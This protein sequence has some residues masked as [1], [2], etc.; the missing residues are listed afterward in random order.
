[1]TAE[2]EVREHVVTRDEAGTRLDRLVADL[3]FVASRAFA[4]RLA[5]RGEIR[6]DGRPASKKHP[7]RAGERVVVN[8]PPPV[9][10]RLVAQDLP[11]DIRYED[12][13]L[14]VLSKPAGLVVHPAAGHADGT[15]V[16][17]LLGYCGDSLGSAGGVNRPGIVHRLDK[18]TSGLM[19]VAKD[20]ATQAAL[21]AELKE[22]RVDRRYLVLVNGVVEADSGVVDAPLGRKPSDRMRMAV[23][24]TQGSR[25]A[26]TS[27]RVLERFAPSATDDGYTLLECRLQTGRTHQV[28]VHM[29]FAGHPVVGDRVYGR[30]AGANPFGLKR[31]WLHAWRLSF[32]HPSSGERVEVEDVPP[33]DLAAVLEELEPRSA[34]RTDAGAA[35]L[36]PRAE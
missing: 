25:A 5:E 1:M 33:A 23:T 15:L 27:F 11:L 22:R 24:D 4:A 29:A 10:T 32:I 13:W 17:A 18:D 3:G 14:L 21:A 31:Q 7:V 2:P 20:D 12:D 36:D 19:M 16:N 30:S 35:C 28:R 8:L 6:V 34:G 9:E 26:V